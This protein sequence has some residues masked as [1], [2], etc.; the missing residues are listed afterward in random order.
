MAMEIPAPTRATWKS[1]TPAERQ[2]S[3][4]AVDAPSILRILLATE[5][6]GGGVGRHV[7]DLALGLL[8]R[9]HQVTVVYSPLRAEPEFARRVTA[10][11][12]RCRLHQLAMKRSP[13]PHDLPAVLALRRI[14]RT[15]G[16]YHV[17][18]G[19]SSKA[20]ALLRLAG[21]GH[22]ARQVYTPHALVTLSPGLGALSGWFYRAAE[23]TLSGITDA[24]ICVSGEEAAHAREIGIAGHRIA[25]VPNGI[26]SLPAADRNAA[27]AELRA[28]PDEVVIGFVGRITEQK[29]VDG[30]IRAFAAMPGS[31]ARLAIV[32]DGPLL[33]DARQLAD[34]LGVA[35]RT[36][37]TGAADGPRLM[38]GFDLFAL[39]SAYEGF[40]YVLLEALARGLPIVTTLVGGARATVRDGRNGVIVPQGQMEA[41]AAALARL[42]G[43]PALRRAMGE[44]SR[45]ISLDFTANR[46]LEQTLAV[47]RADQ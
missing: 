26:A 34:T 28:A 15:T 23:R 42:S 7:V 46:M 14:I 39:P 45:R 20:G 16:P 6:A 8:D 35:G 38:A 1:T 2:P 4:S 40:P 3:A 13:G 41:F 43:D 11:A 33:P 32:G 47:Y 37:F 25:V 9:G 36:V 30:L 5:A 21:L 10:L 44:E 27:R 29:G 24:L 12:G 18:H 22:G 31:H 19:H 17:L